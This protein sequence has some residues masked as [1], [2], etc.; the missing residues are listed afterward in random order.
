MLCGTNREEQLNPMYF[1]GTSCSAKKIIIIYIIDREIC[2][3]NGFVQ[4]SLLFITKTVKNIV[5]EMVLYER[6]VYNV[7]L[8]AI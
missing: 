8:T 7:M 5:V 4:N 2:A 6:K 1:G 3:R